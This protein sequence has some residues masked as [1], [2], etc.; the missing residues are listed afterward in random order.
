MCPV[1]EYLVRVNDDD[2]IERYPS[3]EHVLECDISIVGL[4]HHPDRTKSRSQYKALL[5]MRL[6]EN[7][8]KDYQAMYYL[9]N[10]EWSSGNVAAAEELFLEI[11][12][13][14][15]AKLSVIGAAMSLGD[16]YANKKAE[17]AAQ[18]WYQRAIID[19]ETLETVCYIE[20]YLKLVN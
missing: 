3:S 10:E 11:Y 1:H 17:D 20:P 18:M 13:H 7:P 19:E 8:E 6:Q 15:S 5:K 2:Y 4:E 16:I 9:A 14:D 12:K